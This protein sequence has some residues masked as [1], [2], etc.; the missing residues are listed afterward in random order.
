MLKKYTLFLFAI[1]ISDLIHR[2]RSSKMTPRKAPDTLPITSKALQTRPHL[3]LK[4]T[5][6]RRQ[7]KSTKEQSFHFK[8][9][10]NVT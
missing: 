10:T 4:D 1:V 2:L 5:S 7:F 3:Q 9:I 8:Q 6:L